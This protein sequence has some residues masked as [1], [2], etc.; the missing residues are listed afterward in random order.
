[1][2]GMSESLVNKFCPM[3]VLAGPPGIYIRVSMA[4]IVPA[5]KDHVQKLCNPA[6]LIV[7]MKD[8]TVVG[9]KAPTGS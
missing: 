9:R 4:A 7:L 1:M 2:H 8:T 5:T 3:D 6:A